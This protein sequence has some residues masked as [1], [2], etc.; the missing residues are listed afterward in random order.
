MTAFL[1]GITLMTG[2]IAGF[3]VC[4]VLVQSA[5]ERSNAEI[6]SNAGLKLVKGKW[7]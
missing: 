1:F 7:E 2:F 5:M 4:L 6:F 3:V